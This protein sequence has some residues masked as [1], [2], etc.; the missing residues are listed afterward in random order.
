MANMETVQRGGAVLFA[1]L[2]MLIVSAFSAVT[3]GMFF[4]EYFSPALTSLFPENM[5]FVVAFAIGA[6][7]A[8]IGAWAWFC[9]LMFMSRNVTQYVAAGAMTLACI[10]TS[11]AAS[12]LFILLSFPDLELGAMLTDSIALAS[13][14]VI[15]G[16]V[17]A[18][19]FGAFVLHSRKPLN[20]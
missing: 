2:F 10:G 11:I 12:V 4:G 18:H 5:A 7:A 8:D 17:A 3:S 13:A 1:T 6:I 16:I 15:S 19:F 20:D 9:A 14:L